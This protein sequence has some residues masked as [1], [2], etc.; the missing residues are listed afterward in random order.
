MLKFVFVVD[1]FRFNFDL[2]SC[3]VMCYRFFLPLSQKDFF[4]DRKKTT[5]KTSTDIMK[6]SQTKLVSMKQPLLNNI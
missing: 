4:F 3:Y 1:F 2:Y 6:E 5:S